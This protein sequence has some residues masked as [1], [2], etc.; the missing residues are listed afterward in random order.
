MS[1]TFHSKPPIT[2]QTAPGYWSATCTE[3]L[4]SV[5]SCG[6]VACVI[7]G[8]PHHPRTTERGLFAEIPCVVVRSNE[9]KCDIYFGCRKPTLGPHPEPFSSRH[10]VNINFRRHC[11]RRM[12][13]RYA[14]RVEGEL[15]LR[16]GKVNR[17]SFFNI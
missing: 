13:Y 10:H 6:R 16:P 7:V 8:Y 4:Q 2:L 14:T 9:N 11:Q 5:E 3:W 15:G 12:P 1:V 17:I